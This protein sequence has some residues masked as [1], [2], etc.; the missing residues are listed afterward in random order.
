MPEK[1]IIEHGRH[2]KYVLPGAGSPP[3]EL[4]GLRGAYAL[5]DQITEATAQNCL[6]LSVPEFLHYLDRMS[7]WTR[8]T[9]GPQEIKPREYRNTMHA[10]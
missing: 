8:S 2:K 6:S 7:E 3:P 10:D 9:G 4:T 1:R 5:R